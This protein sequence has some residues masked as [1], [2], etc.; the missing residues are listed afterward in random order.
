MQEIVVQEVVEDD[1]DVEVSQCKALK[2]GKSFKKFLRSILEHL[3]ENL[4]ELSPQ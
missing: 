4:V 3:P 2:Y 1:S